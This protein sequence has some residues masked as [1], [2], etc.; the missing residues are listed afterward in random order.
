[1]TKTMEFK[2]RCLCGEVAF[3]GE[4]PDEPIS[5]CHCKQCRQWGSGPF[6]AYSLP[7][8]NLQF[9]AGE[10]AVKYY[11]SSD[12]ARRGFCSKC[13]SNLFWHADRH[14]QWKDRISIAVGALEQPTGL[15]AG[16]HIFCAAKADYYEIEDGRPQYAHED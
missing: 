12:F 3:E 14:P 15:S 6:D 16:N 4:A 8:K 10:D 2:G 1:M 13:G 7:L 5:T 9:T 11:E